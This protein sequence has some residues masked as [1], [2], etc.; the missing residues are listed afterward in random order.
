MKRNHMLKKMICASLA[1]ALF[2]PTAHAY[3]PFDGTDAGV[4]EADTFELEIGAS[5]FHQAGQR[6]LG[7]PA[8][9]LNFGLKGD[10]EIVFDGRLEHRQGN[11][12]DGARDGL[13]DTALSLKHVWKAGSLQDK[14]GLSFATEC[15]VLL[16]TIL[17]ESGT[18]ATCAGIV[19]QKWETGMVHFNLGLTRARDKENLRFAS[20]IV[21]GPEEWIVRPVMELSTEHGSNGTH[22]NAVLAG[23]IWKV[24][25]HLDIDAALRKQ[26]EQGETGREIRLGATWSTPF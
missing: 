22:S 24:G 5:R 6:T 11:D 12:I 1:Y 4:A 21:E 7:I 15:G 13:T 3:R 26:R 10:T 14:E 16:P 18:G 17:G 2:A 9:T 8:F 25:E 19:S 23:V 20:V